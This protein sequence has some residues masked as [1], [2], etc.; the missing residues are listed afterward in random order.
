[1][2]DC[3]T[4]FGRLKR[5]LGSGYVRIS[6]ILWKISTGPILELDEG[7]SHVEPLHFT[8]KS[9]LGKGKYCHHSLGAYASSFVKVHNSTPVVRKRNRFCWNYDCLIR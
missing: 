2:V 4:P 6:Y 3:P 1:M 9:I 5:R 8:L 7:V